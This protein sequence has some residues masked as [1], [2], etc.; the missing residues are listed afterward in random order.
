MKLK[1]SAGLD[2]VTEGKTLKSFVME[3]SKRPVSGSQITRVNFSLTEQDIDNFDHFIKE[4]GASRV[5]VLRASMNALRMLDEDKRNTLIRQ[6]EIA[7]P[8]TGKP[9]I[10]R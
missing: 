3:A 8:K 5:A 1:K 7:S 9:P 2:T 10:K 4:S 6:A